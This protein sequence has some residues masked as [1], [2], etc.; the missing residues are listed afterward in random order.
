M[1]DIRRGRGGENAL[2]NLQR[3]GNTARA[4]FLFFPFFLSFFL[5]ERRR[6]GLTQER[7]NERLRRD[8]GVREGGKARERERER[9]KRVCVVAHVV[10]QRR[11][12][13]ATEDDTLGGEERERETG[14]R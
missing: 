9:E 6:R 12:R 11:V 7:K 10:R 1:G 4:S 3:E 8:C 2:S 13:A 14:E 5:S